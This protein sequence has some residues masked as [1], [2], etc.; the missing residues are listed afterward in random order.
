MDQLVPKPS[1]TLIWYGFLLRLQQ[2]TIDWQHLSKLYNLP[3]PMS[4]CL[5]RQDGQARKIKEKPTKCY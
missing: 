2:S 4:Q 3:R 5:T 1:K